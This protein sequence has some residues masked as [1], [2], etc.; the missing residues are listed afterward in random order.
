MGQGLPSK[1]GKCKVIRQL[2]QGATA[3]VLLAKHEG[4]GMLVAVKV[5]RKRLSES[6]PEFA[7]RFLREAQ[8][9]ARLEHPNIVRVIDCGVQDG[10]HFMVMDYVDGHNCMQLLSEYSDGV[11]W[12]E[13]TGIVLQ[14]T[15]A[16]SFAA[17]RDIIHRDVKPSNIMLDSSGRVRVTDLGLAKLAVEGVAALTQELHTVGTPNYMSPE[18]IRSPARLDLRADIYSLGATF[19]HL[20][21]G[22]PPFVGDN[23]MDVVT[24]HLTEPLVP[25]YKVRRDLPA[26]VSKV[27]CKMMAKSAKRRYQDY[28]TLQ[29]DLHNLQSGNDVTALDFRETFT[30]SEEDVRLVKLLERLS[31]GISVEVDDD[32]E[33]SRPA[34]DHE[35]GTDANGSSSLPP[36]S[37]ADHALY[38]PPASDEGSTLV[39]G[40]SAGPDSAIWIIFV[41]A[42]I[43]VLVLIAIAALTVFFSG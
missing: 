32:E 30:T 14:A 18:Q 3:I 27:I 9:A 12:R 39:A 33:P 10:Y 15:E 28:E 13:A 19:Y 23:P 25:P 6:R 24:R 2:G 34:D 43:G 17:E 1:F 21:T 5:L 36:F 42:L 35:R 38:R 41:V 11:P 37:P 29:E 31:A 20:V 4:L 7:E 16:L 26:A 8:M 40:S 22:R